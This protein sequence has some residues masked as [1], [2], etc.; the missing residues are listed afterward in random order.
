MAS[1]T[2]YGGMENAAAIFYATELFK[3][4]SSNESAHCGTKLRIN[5]SATLS[6]SV[7][8]PDGLAVGR[9][10]DLLRCALD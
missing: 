9:F 3:P 7:S 10:R 8:G 1:S 2:R 6:L 5:G 4:G